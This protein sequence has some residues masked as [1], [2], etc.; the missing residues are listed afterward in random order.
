MVVD[1]EQVY[2]K[3]YLVRIRSAVFKRRELYAKIVEDRCQE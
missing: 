1:G 3:W 2:G